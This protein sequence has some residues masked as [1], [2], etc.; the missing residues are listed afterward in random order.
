MATSHPLLRQG[1]AA[2]KQGQFPEAIR[3]LTE[4]CQQS[5]SSHESIQAQMGLVQAYQRTGEWTPAIDLCQQLAGHSDLQVQTWAQQALQSV[6][7]AQAKAAVEAV[8]GETGKTVPPLEMATRTLDEFRSFCNQEMVGDLKQIEAD[9]KQIVR[10]IQGVAVLFLIVLLL[11]VK[12]VPAIL[13]T[14]AAENKQN[15]AQQA[16]LDSLCA[17]LTASP[18][19][20]R[21]PPNFNDPATRFQPRPTPAVETPNP[22]PRPLDQ[23]SP[24]EKARL[25]QETNVRRYCSERQKTAQVIQLHHRNSVAQLV[26]F[27]LLQALF[28]CFVVLTLSFWAWI[29]FYTAASDTYG[30]GFKEKIIQKILNFID[31]DQRLTYSRIGDE[32]V[33]KEAL[34]SCKLF[35]GLQSSFYLKQDD[36]VEGKLGQT[37]IVFSEVCAEVEFRHNLRGLLGFARWALHLINMAISALPFLVYLLGI[38]RMTIV[39]LVGAPYFLRRVVAGRR[40]DY[41][42]FVEA[43]LQ[44]ELSRRPAFKGLFFHANFSK[45]FRGQTFILPNALKSNLPVLNWN[46]GQ[47]VNLEDPEFKQRFTV[48]GNDQVE[49][50]YILSTSLMQRLVDFRNKAKRPLY[51]SF[52]KNQIYLAI[53]YE[54]DLFEP[55]LFTTMLNFNPLR[56][57]FETLQLMIGIVS[58]LNLNVRIWR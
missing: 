52:A 4:F 42:H 41:D 18:T 22:A 40:I 30:R 26:Q 19:P 31:V 38:L 13:D 54:E 10:A 36:W 15:Q 6:Q 16:H 50:R 5:A 17:S 46:R 44:G 20:T 37:E 49:A 48:Y 57:Y 53:P 45:S 34:R 39:L 8:N 33:T 23:L 51:I 55:T 24:E 14:M 35:P 56:E 7:K 43:V 11:I 32:W 1:L 3:L 47:R 25:R 2:L 27:R 29:A 21:S 28:L 58:D 12:A 9:R